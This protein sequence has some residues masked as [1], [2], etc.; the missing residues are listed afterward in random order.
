VKQST[1]G[2]CPFW[3]ASSGNCPRNTVFGAKIQE[4]KKRLLQMRLS[5]N[6][7]KVLV[8]KCHLKISHHLDE[9]H[10]L[11]A[12]VCSS[13]LNSFFN[14]LEVSSCTRGKTTKLMQGSK[15]P[16]TTIGCVAGAQFTT[17]K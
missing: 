2:K 8:F 17:E 1:R 9:I 15:K 16:R 13:F 14:T 11:S 3:K 12:S 10:I 4:T 5:F 7:E 6:A